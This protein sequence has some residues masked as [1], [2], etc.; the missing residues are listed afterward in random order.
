MKKKCLSFFILC[1][2]ITSLCLSQRI[3]SGEP[4]Q[5]VGSFNG[6]NTS[7]YGTDYRT[8][9]YRTVSTQMPTTTASGNSTDGPT[10]GRGQWATTIQIPSS[11]AT[12]T[13]MTG[14]GGNG[15]L[16]ISGPSTNRFQNKWVFNGVGQGAMD[17]INGC[18]FQ[19]ST[20]MGLDLS[21]PAFYTFVFNDGGYS[22]TNAKYY[23]GK[24]DSMP[25]KV[26]FQYYQTNMDSSVT[27]HIK[28]SAKPS[29]QENIFV[30]YMN[31]GSND[32]SGTDPTYIV[33][34]TGADTNWTATI[35]PYDPNSTIIHFYIF[36]STRSLAQELIATETEKSLAVI[37]YDDGTL[38]S[39]F[40]IPVPLPITCKNFTGLLKDNT[41]KLEWQTCSDVSISGFEVEKNMAG[42]WK[43]IASLTTK[44]KLNNEYSYTDAAVTSSN[45]YRIKFI[46]YNGGISYSNVVSINKSAAS[47]VSLY[48]TIISNHNINIRIKETTATKM[49]IAIVN[50]NGQVLQQRTINVKAGENII[51]HQL[52]N[53]QQGMYFVEVTDGINKNTFSIFIQ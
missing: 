52:P 34:A 3:Y 17:G 30:R 33:Q 31:T 12:A 36:T 39:N 32:F 10:D 48:P 41:I 1:C 6:Y 45:V 18:N 7:P 51:T 8:T 15:F 35:P 42:T 16:F 4:V 26:L 2:S 29:P 40:V 24:T 28:T 14:G 43:K 22:S 9:K 47:G 11:D 19:G 50:V 49:N 38:H 37:D 23:V 21:S 25:V 20:D 5:V 44:D 13:N 53:I 27:V 46:E